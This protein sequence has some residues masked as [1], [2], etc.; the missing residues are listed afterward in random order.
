[1]WQFSSSPLPFC[2][3]CCF[4]ETWG[5]T[6]WCWRLVT[7][8]SRW[9]VLDWQHK[10]VL[11]INF[12]TVWA[13]QC[14]FHFPF[15]GRGNSRSCVGAGVESQLDPTPFRLLCYWA[16]WP[17]PYVTCPH[18]MSNCV[19]QHYNGAGAAGKCRPHMHHHPSQGKNQ[20]HRHF[21]LQPVILWHFGVC[22]LPPLHCG[23]HT[24]GPLGV[25]LPVMQTGA[26]YPVCVCDCVCVVAGVHCPGEASAHH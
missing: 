11:S 6:V 13:F 14:I 18:N 3:R 21:H 22:L 25:W 7:L 23:V 10:S 16:W 17:V 15:M 24:D 26:V 5:W 20:C 19:V 4:P 2:L 8:R 12:D 1:M 9:D